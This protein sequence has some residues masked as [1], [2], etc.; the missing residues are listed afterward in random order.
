MSEI[1]EARK[2]VSSLIFNVLTE[3]ITVRKAL[4][5]F[6]GNVNDKSINCAW[7]A[8]LHY[9]ADEDYRLKNPDF[10]SVQTDSLEMIAFTLQEGKVLPKNII[11]DY[12]KYYE[13]A[14]IAKPKGFKGILQA[15]LRF[16]I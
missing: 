10:L 2:F 16:T 9:E 7:H 4:S 13:M 6:P 1:E 5:L 8:L 14:P 11:S 3:K 15:I 12:Y